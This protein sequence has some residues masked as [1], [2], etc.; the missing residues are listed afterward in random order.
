MMWLALF[1]LGLTTYV[2]VYYRVRRIT[3]TPWWILWLTLMLPPFV[4]AAWALVHGEREPV[5]PALLIGSFTASFILYI[6]L[7]QTGRISGAPP[8]PTDIDQA[9]PETVNQSET[10]SAARPINKAEEGALQNCFPWSVYYLQSLEYR[11]QAMICR[12][13]LRSNPEVAYQTV[14]ENVQA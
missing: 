3:R 5:P 4:I 12:G 7:V 13:Q 1:L 8:K 11:P 6:W 14:R 9:P 10:S 2:I